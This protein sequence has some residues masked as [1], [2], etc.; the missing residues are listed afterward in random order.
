[1]GVGTSGTLGVHGCRSLGLDAGGVVQKSLCRTVLS[2][3]TVFFLE[4]RL[5]VLMRHDRKQKENEWGAEEG[6]HNV[7]CIPS[8]PRKS[9]R[10][11]LGTPVLI[12][13]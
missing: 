6:A 12:I 8:C 3:R 9:G 10:P 11:V 2:L 7:H 13:P 1:M 5:G 4:R